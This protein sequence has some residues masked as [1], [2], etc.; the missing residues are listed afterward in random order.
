MERKTNL[1]LPFYVWVGGEAAKCPNAGEGQTVAAF[2]CSFGMSDPPQK[3]I[4]FSVQGV[5][6]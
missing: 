5:L 6:Y 2:L 1:T 3:E 4:F